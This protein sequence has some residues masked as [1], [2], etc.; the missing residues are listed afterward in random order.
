MSAGGRIRAAQ[1]PES[2]FDL[3]QPTLA[4][5]AKLQKCTFYRLLTNIAL[6]LD[7]HM[8]GDALMIRNLYGRMVINLAHY[9]FVRRELQMLRQSA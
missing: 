9:N 4:E 2:R 5:S 7:P 8:K 3:Q 1:A 6:T